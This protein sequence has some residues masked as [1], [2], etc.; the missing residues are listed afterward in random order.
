MAKADL[1][2][3]RLREILDYA[4]E[5]GVFTWRQQLSYRGFPTAEEAH[6]AYLEAKRR[7]HAGCTI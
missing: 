6:A 2:A 4:P 3:Q 7:L 1:T 5:T